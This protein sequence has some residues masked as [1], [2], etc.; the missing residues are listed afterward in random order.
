MRTHFYRRR[1][2]VGASQVRLGARAI[3][4]DPRQVARAFAL[5]SVCRTIASGREPC[6]DDRTRRRGRRRRGRAYYINHTHARKII[7]PRDARR[8]SFADA[9]AIHSSFRYKL[10]GSEER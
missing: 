4:T 2:S 8:Q 9:D 3:A 6:D 10:E 7:R 5:G 1:A